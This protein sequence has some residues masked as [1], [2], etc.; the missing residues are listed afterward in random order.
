MIKNVK[1]RS[2]SSE[3]APE[4]FG[5]KRG[6]SLKN[7][8]IMRD[9]TIEGICIRRVNIYY[10]FQTNVVCKQLKYSGTSS[11]VYCSSCGSVLTNFSYDD[12]QCSG[13][14]AT[15]DACPH[16]NIHDCYANEG[17]WVP[18]NLSG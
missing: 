18:C 6:L 4:Y 10:I 16:L 13:T 17:V 11:F 7:E 2:T 1:G 8:N 3:E 14:E 15:L 5:A 12:V 9:N